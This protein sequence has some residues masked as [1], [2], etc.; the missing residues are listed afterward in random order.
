MLYARET[1]LPE[2]TRAQLAKPAPARHS[3]ARL[4]QW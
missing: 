4:A 2:A 3:S 1:S